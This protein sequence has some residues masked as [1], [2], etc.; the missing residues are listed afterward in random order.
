MR[1]WHRSGPRLPESC[2]RLTAEKFPQHPKFGR[3]Y[4][5]GDLVHRNGDGTYIF[6]GRIDSQ[7][8]I[9]G[10]RVELEA[11]ESRLAAC[12]RVREAVCRVQ[13]DGAQ[14]TLVAFIVPQDERDPP[15]IEEL[16][17]S[18]REVLPNYMIPSRM[19]MLPKLPVT[20]GG[21]L[22][23]RALPHLEPHA[24]QGPDTVVPP[25][26]RL[27]AKVA[28]ALREVLY[29]VEEVSIHDDFFVDLGGDSLRAA[30][31][32]TLL[33]D[34]TQTASL[35]V[36]DVYEARS[37][38]AIARRAS[39]LLPEEVAR[40]DR[41][42]RSTGRPLLTTL[43]Q[44]FWLLAGLTVGAL[45]AYFVWFQVF[46]FL[47]RAGTG[48]AADMRTTPGTCRT[49]DIHTLE[50]AAGGARKEVPDWS[51]SAA[52]SPLVEQ[53]L[54]A[55]LDGPTCRKHRTLV[56]AD[57]HRFP[58]RD[59]ARSRVPASAGGCTFIVASISSRVDGTCWRLVMT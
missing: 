40:E 13:H 58:T 24:R 29:L 36:R 16:Q 19:A 30:Q 27:E 52:T 49:G 35:T 14:Q 28:A 5:T 34:D 20:I 47:L 51:L 48:P 17:R 54:R 33:R 26:N 12:D 45:V 43:V 55:Q 56:A 25:R 46:P 22:N 42:V 11:I 1:G 50:R 23:R 10:Y 57:G 7:V 44:A 8:K 32:V 41:S 3:I 59:L 4:R 37:V 38:A 18:L 9:R 53:F 15:P 6:H 21:K 2:T 31:L 39:P